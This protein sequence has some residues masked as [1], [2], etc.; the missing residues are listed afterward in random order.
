MQTRPGEKTVVQR[1]FYVSVDRLG[2]DGLEMR[3]RNTRLWIRVGQ[4]WKSLIIKLIKFV[5]QMESGSKII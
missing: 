1:Y 3:L 4:S 2:L 5:I